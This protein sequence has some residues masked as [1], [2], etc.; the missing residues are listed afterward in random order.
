MMYKKKIESE[1]GE[2]GAAYK[3]FDLFVSIGSN[4]CFCIS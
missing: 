4:F 1:I 3:K 2:G